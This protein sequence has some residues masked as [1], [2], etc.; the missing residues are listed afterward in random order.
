MR[1]KNDYYMIKSQIPENAASFLLLSNNC[2]AQVIWDSQ[3]INIA[4]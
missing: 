1:Q 3:K 4:F 2:N